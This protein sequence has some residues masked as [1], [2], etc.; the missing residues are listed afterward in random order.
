MDHFLCEVGRTQETHYTD[1]QLVVTLID[2][3][4]GGSGTM[5]KTLGFAFFFCLKNPDILHRV[6]EEVERVTGHKDGVSLEDRP[7]LVLTEATLLEVARLGSVL[8]IAPPRLCPEN[9][10]VKYEL[11]FCRS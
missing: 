4:T 3:F 5:S 1:Q 7:S 8:P 10:Q 2:F 11:A 6:Q 9:V